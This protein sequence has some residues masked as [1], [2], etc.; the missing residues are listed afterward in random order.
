MIPDKYKGWPIVALLL[1]VVIRYLKSTTKPILENKKLLTSIGFFLI[2]T[3]SI[4]YSVD[5]SYALKKLETGSSLVVFPVVFY[6]IGHNSVVFKEQ[7]IQKIKF[8]FIISLLFFL[9]ATFIY[10][11]LTKDSYTLKNTLEHYTYL[12]DI[13]IGSYSIHSIYLSIYIGIALIFAISLIKTN[14]PRRNIFLCFTL[15]ILIAFT[16][17]LNKKGPIIS[18]SIIGLVFVFKDRFSLRKVIYA[19]L[20]TTILGSLII[21]APRFKGE[22]KFEKLFEIGEGKKT[23]SALRIQIY[24]CAVQ[25]V[26]KSP[27]YGYGWGD[28]KTVLNQCYENNNKQFLLE[29]NYNSH[30]QYLSI[31]LST[32]TL[33]FLA[34]V[35]YIFVVLKASYKEHKVLFFLTLYF[36]LNMFTENIL[37]REDGVIIIALLLNLFFFNTKPKIQ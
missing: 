7:I 35:Y 6:L 2:L 16:A 21:F 31:F 22:N 33:G 29:D 27:I 11:Y 17:I 15:F 12:V 28:T 19:T 14:A 37:E 9:V 24:K 10:L 20:L 36:C 25:L 26:A 34:F 13:G 4:L 23:S 1:W 18:L 32:G 8:T 5:L 3:F 30:N